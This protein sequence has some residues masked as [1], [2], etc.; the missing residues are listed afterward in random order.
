VAAIQG[1]SPELRKRIVTGFVGAAAL[2]LLIAFGG[3]VGI[4][5][6]ATGLSLLMIDEFSRIVFSLED[7]EEKRYALLFA[8]WLIALGALILAHTEFELLVFSFL[9]LFIYYLVTAQ[10]HAEQM[11]VHFKELMFSIFGLL[12]L[13]ALPTF[14]PKIHGAPNGAHWVIV[15]LFINWATDTGA[16]FAGR[17]YGKTPLYPLISPKKTREGG[18]GGLVTAWVVTLVYKLILFHGMPWGAVIIVPPL[19]SCV[20][21]A[22]DLCESLLKRAFD[23][24]DSGSFLPGH[25]GFLDRFDGV[26][27]SLP[28]MYACI[29]IFA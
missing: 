9:A 27:F 12:Y 1:M 4:F 21:Q 22:G 5:I 28:I 8:A 18:I 24:K 10:R 6:L 13:A 25:G 15:F 11:A 26:V 20:A 17:K 14:L 2:L 3:S 23:R 29:R 7:Q 16:Y 19:V